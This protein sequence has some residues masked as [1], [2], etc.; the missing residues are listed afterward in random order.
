MKNGRLKLYIG[1]LLTVGTLCLFNGCSDENPTGVNTDT[2]TDPYPLK[3]GN[4]WDYS[5]AQSIYVEAQEDSLPPWALSSTGRQYVSITRTEAI[6]GEEAFG[7]RHH[8]VMGWLTDPLRADTTIDTHCMAPRSYRI[9]L[10][11]FLYGYD[12][13]SAIPLS[14]ATGEDRLV[15][16]AGPA[17]S[18]R[19]I[20]LNTLAR[21]LLD[22]VPMLTNTSG[23]DALLVSDGVINQDDF[24]AY[25][26]DY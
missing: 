26:N 13:A 23:L 7:V 21:Q 10:T 11:G 6:T 20:P 19:Y 24:F 14:L 17:G 8:H 16:R 18:G 1:C 4:Y 3:L 15:V 12:K 25:E 22:P 9:V 5:L 2:V